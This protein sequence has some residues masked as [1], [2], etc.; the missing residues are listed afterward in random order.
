MPSKNRFSCVPGLNTVT[1]FAPGMLSPRRSM[2][3]S[4]LASR[5]DTSRRH[6]PLLGATPKTNTPVRLEAPTG[7]SPALIDATT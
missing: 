3:I 4:A 1:E 5:T 2:G 6:G 7:A